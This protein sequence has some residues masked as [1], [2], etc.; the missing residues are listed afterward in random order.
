[1]SDRSGVRITSK[2]STGRAHNWDQDRLNRI[3]A[4]KLGSELT[5]ARVAGMRTRARLTPPPGGNGRLS[6]RGAHLRPMDGARCETG[7]TG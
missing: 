6:L 2:H 4:A 3:N 7:A 5:F 1:M